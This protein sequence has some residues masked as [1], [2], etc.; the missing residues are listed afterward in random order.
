[1]SSRRCRRGGRTIGTTQKSQTLL[2]FELNVDT[3]IVPRYTGDGSLYF[4][5]VKGSK[6]EV[7]LDVTLEHDGT[8]T[9]EKTNFRNETPR[10]IR[11]KFEGSA[12]NTAGT[13]T[14]KTLQIDLAGKWKKFEKLAEIDGNDVVTGKFKAAYNATAAL[15]AQVVIVNELASLP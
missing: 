8:A 12:L 5:G 9:A 1:M 13:W 10:Q 2:G 6:P 14:Y 11:L 4:S 7:E 15:F 3:G